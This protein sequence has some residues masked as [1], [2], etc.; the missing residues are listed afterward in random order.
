MERRRSEMGEDTIE[1][2]INRCDK[3]CNG[4]HRCI[5]FSQ[6][7]SNPRIEANRIWERTKAARGPRGCLCS[8]GSG[9]SLTQ[10]VNKGRNELQMDYGRPCPSVEGRGEQAGSRRDNAGPGL[11]SHGE[12]TGQWTKKWASSHRWGL[13][14]LKQ[15]PIPLLTCPLTSTW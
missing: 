4:L 5:W 9:Q 2:K 1:K 15:L 3:Y 14:Y 10:R 13:C 8:P 6:V 7:S 11:T 12:P